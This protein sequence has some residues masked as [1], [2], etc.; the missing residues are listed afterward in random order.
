MDPRTE[1][2]ERYNRRRSALFRRANNFPVI[3]PDQNIDPEVLQDLEVDRRRAAYTY[4][5]GFDPAGRIADFLSVRKSDRWRTRKALIEKFNAQNLALRRKIRENHILIK[6]I[7][8]NQ[9]KTR[10]NWYTRTT[11]EQ[12]IRSYNQWGRDWR[13]QVEELGLQHP[14]NG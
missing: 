10:G 7:E 12:Q 1:R 2:R 14:N 13:R 6:T 3:N 11:T 9:P 8:A 4:E 5:R